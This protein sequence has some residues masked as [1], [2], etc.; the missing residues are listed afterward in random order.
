[1]VDL[2]QDMLLLRKAGQYL[3]V[4]ECEPDDLVNFSDENM[5]DL[6]AQCMFGDE[7]WLVVWNPSYLFGSIR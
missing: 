5:L 7:S 4:F 1:M 6:L 2:T 3:D